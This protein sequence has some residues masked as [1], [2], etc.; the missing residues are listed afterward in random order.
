MSGRNSG[1]EFKA[2]IDNPD[3][4]REY[5][6]GKGCEFIGV[7]NQT[8][9]YLNVRTGRL[10]VREGNIENALIWYDR[11]NRPGPRKCSYIVNNF[12]NNRELAIIKDQLIE[13]LGILAV[14]KYRREIFIL[15]NL[16]FHVDSVGNLGNFFEIEASGED[17]HS[18]KI[19]CRQWLD[20]LGI[21]KEQLLAISYSDMVITK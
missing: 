5:L 11:K 10:K 6:L 15:Q 13:S 3:A 18:M 12:E 2:R 19:N 1:V 21:G 7:D 8:D 4:I 17:E 9:T 14:V 16:K 20:E